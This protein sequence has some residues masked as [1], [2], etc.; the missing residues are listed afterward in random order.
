MAEKVDLSRIRNIGI[1]AHIDAGK[2]TTTERILYYTGVSYRMGEVH[3]GNAVMDWME[4]EQER[5][6][7]ITSAATTCFWGDHRINIIDT[8]GHV[9]FTVEVE[10]SLRV[11]DG[12]VVVF[13]GVGGVEP[14]SET[15]WRQADRY[16]VPRIAFINKLDRVGADYFRAVEMMQSRLRANPVVMQLPIG[17]SERFEGVIDLVKL[18]AYTYESESL[19][20][21]VVEVAIPADMDEQVQRYRQLLVEVAAEND[22][23]LLEHYLGGEELSE[24]DIVRSLRRATL[25]NLIAPVFCGSAFK[26]KGIQHLLDAVVDYLPSP[27]DV[28]PVEG[29]DPKKPEQ[30]IRRK[31]DKDE[32]F[33]ALVFKLWT[34]PFVGHLAFIR[35]Y[36]GEI[37]PGMMVYNPRTEKKERIGKLLKM[38]ANKR[39]EI[40]S[41]TAGDIA[42]VVGLKFAATGDTLCPQNNPLVLESIEFPK[43]VISIAIE[44]K[45]TE[46]EAKLGSAMERLSLEDPTFR[47]KQDSDTGQTVIYGM[48]ELHLEIIVDRLRREFKVHSNVGKP[49]VAYRE[50]V[51]GAVTLTHCYERQLAGRSV[52]AEVKLLVEPADSGEGLVFESRVKPSK[53]FPKSFLDA[54]QR[55]SL[56]AMNS[57]PL[58]G[59]LVVDVRVTLL[60]VVSR[61]A[62]STDLAFQAACGMAVREALGKAVPVLMEPLMAVEIVTPEE[63]IGDV[64]ADL[65]SRQ[66]EITGTDMRPGVQIVNA[67]APLRNMFGYATDSRS[68]TQGRATYT[69]EFK[70]YA[71]VPA[72]LQEQMT[73]QGFGLY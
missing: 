53:E 69:M 35:V 26:N 41:V 27:L 57:G 14:Q 63:F 16:R 29:K 15:V 66:G 24:A 7:T 62:E 47:V 50:T 56:D 59:Y 17:E 11:L 20:A 64:M 40:Q 3:D 6:I 37:K 52:F 44:P 61:E 9:D 68:L 39:E 70:R 32:P 42:A 33:T 21:Q 25:N 28:P 71:P 54:C 51:T 43:P 19:G 60:D 67:L 65:N 13:C 55:G 48:G 8:P 30:L 4:Q 38:H 46:D 73:S 22:E 23:T 36:S 45:S 72:K 12:A 10:R 2:T 5:G 49:Q 58:L 18:K 1:A 34:D 31:A